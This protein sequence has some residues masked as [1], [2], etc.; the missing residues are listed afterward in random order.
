[1]SRM[2]HAQRMLGVVGFAIGAT[3]FA[4]MRPGAPISY[5]VVNVFTEL[6]TPSLTPVAPVDSTV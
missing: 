6:D 4:T 5:C 3:E 2:A 1:M